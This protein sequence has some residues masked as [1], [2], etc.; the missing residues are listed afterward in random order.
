MSSQS[1]PDNGVVNHGPMAE[2]MPS[3]EPEEDS[4]W[5][6][7][8][9][10]EEAALAADAI[11]PEN[12]T[13]VTIAGVTMPIGIAVANWD[14]SWIVS[15]ILAILLSDVMGH[16]VVKTGRP[17]G[18]GT[19]LAVT[20]CPAGFNNYSECEWPPTYH[21]ALEIWEHQSH[22]PAFLSVLSEMGE[23]KAPANLG[24][25]G[26]Q[27]YEGLFVMQRAY[28]KCQADFGL[29]LQYYGNYNLSWFRPDLCTSQMDALNDTDLATCADAVDANY[30]S[31]AQLYFDA[32]GDA[33][34]VQ[35]VNG[36]M[37]LNCLRDRWWIAP[38]C[39]ADHS[40]CAAVMAYAGWGVYIMIQQAAAYS[41][42]LA[43]T[44]AKDYS[45][46]IS[47]NMQIEST[48]WHSTTGAPIAPSRTCCP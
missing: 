13:E 32:T 6:V 26:F 1:V 41:M 21:V 4:Q 47:L 11:A 12:L 40:R 35:S 44:N 25:V 48:A 22:Q 17:N 14:S 37:V 10:E 5:K 46:Y 24:S 43:F 29:H 8:R 42:P 38:S 33:D 36:A 19:L 16:K 7:I 34:G 39:R 31:T 9:A 15:E 45:R 30:P 28:E 23:E 27:G 3:V 18:F 20:G 2:G